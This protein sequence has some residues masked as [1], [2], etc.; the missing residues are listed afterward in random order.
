[1]AV[2]TLD[3]ERGLPIAGMDQLYETIGRHAVDSVVAQIHR[4]ERG[5]PDDPMVALIEGRWEE[6]GGLYP[7]RA[8][9]RVRGVGPTSATLR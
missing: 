3:T 8:P 2:A 9:A 1:V 4:N 5:L 7:L 6:R